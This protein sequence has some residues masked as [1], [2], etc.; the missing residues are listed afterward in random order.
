MKNITKKTVLIIG[1]MIGTFVCVKNIGLHNENVKYQQTI[2]EK[3]L[4]F[5]VIANSDSDEDQNVKLKVRDGV[6]EYLQPYFAGCENK[7]ECKNVIEQRKYE[8]K[9]KA[10]E[11]LRLNGFNET[12][13]V[14]LQNRYF[15]IKNYGDYTFPEGEYEAL[16]IEIGQAEG[17]NWWCVLYPRLCFMDTVSAVVPDDSGNVLRQVLTPEEYDSIY[18]D[19]DKKIVIKSKGYEWVKNIIKK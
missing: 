9:N 2:A 14:K 16:C 18:A 11:I 12:V 5:H 10:E 13:E 4:R 1:I 19:N 15:P 3:I 6:L 8:I 7:T 17:K